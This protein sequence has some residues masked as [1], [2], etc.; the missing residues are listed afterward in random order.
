MIG[1]KMKY[2]KKSKIW[3]CITALFCLVFQACAQSDPL[4]DSASGSTMGSSGDYLSPNMGQAASSTNP[5]E[6]ISGMVQWLDEPVTDDVTESTKT[7]ASSTHG[8]GAAKSTATT[9]SAT[10]TSSA[11]GPDAAESTTTQTSTTPATT[12]ASTTRSTTAT[13]KTPGFEA[14]FTV[15]G[16]LAV[17]FIVLRR[18]R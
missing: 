7:A 12:P 6:G 13:S 17:T 5:D 9:T 11:P 3:L 1:V 15:A 16:L 14:A 10:T 8:P 2:S 4:G 18:R